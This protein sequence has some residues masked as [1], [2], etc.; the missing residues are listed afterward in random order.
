MYM[1]EWKVG[2][3]YS[4]H[5]QLYVH[6]GPLMGLGIVSFVQQLDIT[7]IVISSSMIDVEMQKLTIDQSEWFSLFN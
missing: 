5:F 2:W 6:F 3:S 4:G 1:G 7:C